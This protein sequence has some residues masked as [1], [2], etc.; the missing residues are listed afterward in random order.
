MPYRTKEF[1]MFPWFGGVNT[2]LDPST[3]EPNELTEASN[4]I[5][6]YGKKS[7]RNMRDGINYDWDNGTA[8][9][10]NIIVSFDY[11]FDGPG[12]TNY[13]IGLG[14]DKALRYWTT[15]GHVATATVDSTATAWGSTVTIGS[16]EVL[17]D[18]LIIGVDGAN[19]MPRKW[20]GT[21]NIL[22]LGCELLTGSTAFNTTCVFTVSSANASA[23]ATY[24]NSG[25]TFTVQS[26]IASG[27]TLTCLATGTPAASGTLTKAGG[28]GDSTITYS[29]FTGAVFYNYITTTTV[30]TPSIG[31]TINSFS[32]VTT[33]TTASSTALTS[34]ASTAGVTVGMAVMD[35]SNANIP[36]GTYVTAIVSST[37]VT[38][39]QSATGSNSGLTITFSNGVPP[40]SLV[41]S[42]NTTNST[43]TMMNSSFAL[44]PA[45]GTTNN[46]VY[47]FRSPNVPQATWFREFLGR[48]WC[49]DKANPDDVC[50]STTG[51][52]DEWGG[53]GDSGSL[54]IAPDDGDPI[55]VNGIFPA[56]QQSLYVGKLSKLYVITG[57]T[58]ETFAISLVSD[59]IGVVSHNSIAAVDQDD[60]VFASQKGLHSLMGTV[61]Q[62]DMPEEYLSYAIQK[63]FNQNW[64]KARLPYLW[65]CYLPNINSVAVAVTDLTDSS[66]LNNTLWLYDFPDGYWYCWNDVSCESVFVGNDVDQKRFYFGGSNTRMA[67]SFNGTNYD[68]QSNGSQTTIPINI[69]TGFIFLEKN[70]M[71]VNA[72]KKFSLIY[73]PQGTHS[74]NCSIQIDNYTPQVLNFSLTQASGLLGSTFILGQSV[75]GYTSVTTPYTQQL[76]GYGRSFQLSITQ[77]IQGAPINIL[78][79]AIEYEPLGPAQETILSG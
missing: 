21:N 65:A 18:H 48:L 35:A 8:G 34:L 47:Q 46:L 40:G 15:A 29:A 77:N 10:V 33:G 57:N 78:G 19:N 73:A 3:I 50:Y 55:G 39:S 75:L 32:L 61:Q 20:D 71:L 36:V 60:M 56:F 44:V 38:L 14:S 64:I 17:S 79:F 37:H 62:G 45:N 31:M 7:P 12:K 53:I 58:P 23:G 67:K 69:T 13:K 41:Q 11:W 24:T 1:L 27:T 76:D 26:T 30:P 70:P 42:V 28:T 6:Q 49:N 54:T 59:G 4:I 63:T 74:L 2:S 72:F 51:N 52:I 9:S 43:I 66:T 22:D 68:V 25:Y 5:F 16:M